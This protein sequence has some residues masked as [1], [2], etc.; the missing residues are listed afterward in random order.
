MAAN[1]DVGQCVSYGIERVKSNPLFHILGVF[2]VG[3][4]GSASASILTGPMLVGYYR[5]L[6]KEDAGEKAELN[7]L[8]SGFKEPVMVPSLIAGLLLA[9]AMGILGVLVVPILILAPMLSIAILHVIDGESDGINAIKRSWETFQNDIVMGMV[10]AL[11]LMIVSGLGIFAC[12]IGVFVTGPIACAGMYKLACQL[13][14]GEGG[15]SAGMGDV[16]GEGDAV[17]DEA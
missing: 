8:F 14:A 15:V 2:I 13:G 9:L 12:G 3:V 17:G 10:T 1:V 11:V 16:P 6:R 5:G 4:I 7:D